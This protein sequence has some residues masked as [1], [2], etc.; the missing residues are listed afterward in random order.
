MNNLSVVITTYNSEET[1]QRCLDSVGFADEIVVLDSFSE[2]N[3]MTILEQA[4]AVIKQQK[5][6]GFAQQKQDAINM[7]SHRWILLLDSDEY[8][9]ESAQQA[10]KNWQSEAADAQG[11]SLPRIEWVFWRWSHRWVRH[12]RFLRLFDKQHMRIEERL[13]HE[14]VTVDGTA[15]AIDAPI[16]HYGERSISEKI[17]KIH[18][19]SSLA[20]QDKFNKGKRCGVLRIVFYPGFYFIRQYLFKRQIFN[21]MAGLINATI[22]SYYAFLKYAKLY[23]LQKNRD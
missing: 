22:N 23:E 2:D 19:Y 15:S 13:V 20:A 10:I 17:K 21:G 9:S 1:V 8:L 14:S 5:F 11:Y 3:T 7:A 18:H 6:K 16:M 12:N 4:G